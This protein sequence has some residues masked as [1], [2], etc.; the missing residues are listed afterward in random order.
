CNEFAPTNERRAIGSI[1][2][3]LYPHAVDRCSAA[4]EVGPSRHADGAGATCLHAL[5]PGYAVRSAGSDLAEPR[6]VRTL[7]R[8]RLNAAVVGAPSHRHARGECRIR[9]ARAT[10]GFTRRYSSLPPT[11]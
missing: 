8:S 5:E 9:T 6:S 10:R 2:H 3:Q 1:V 7:Q 11:R 4:G